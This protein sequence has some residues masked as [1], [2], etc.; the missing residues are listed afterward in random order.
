MKRFDRLLAMALALS[1]RKRLRAED[2][3]REFG[4]SVRTVY[5]DLRALAEAGFPIEGT[6]GDGYV[7]PTGAQLRPLNLTSDE[8]EALLV[9]TRLLEAGGDDALRARL[10]SAVLKLEAALSTE[11]AQRLRQSRRKVLVVEGRRTIPLAPLLAAINDRQVVEIDYDGIA[12]GERT[13]RAI[14]PLGLVRFG[15]SWHLAAYC[16]LREDLRVFRA[17]RIASLRPTGNRYEDRPGLGF[18]DFVRMSRDMSR[19]SMAPR[20]SGSQNDLSRAPPAREVD[21]SAASL[22]ERHDVADDRREHATREHREE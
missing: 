9:A 21:Q 18:D 16:R 22:G 6:P 4:V 1:A 3:Q 14:E 15:D 8:V 5:R 11:A 17:D 13:V 19:D 10:L 12:R 7:V 2:L 20:G